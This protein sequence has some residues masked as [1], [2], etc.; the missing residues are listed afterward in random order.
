MNSTP[1]LFTLT[2]HL[3]ID[4]GHSPRK[5]TFMS[6]T[7]ANAL[8]KSDKAQVVLSS[9]SRFPSLLSRRSFPTY[10]F[11]CGPSFVELGNQ[12]VLH[13]NPP[14]S[15]SGFVLTVL[16]VHD[17]EFEDTC[18]HNPLWKTLSN[19]VFEDLRRT[20]A[21][22]IYLSG[23]DYYCLVLCYCSTLINEHD[24]IIYDTLFSPSYL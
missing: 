10:S 2:G 11:G 22:N 5:I 18:S 17:S 19:H 24:V 20:K 12:P 13:F 4:A 3:F 9:L 6:I 21:P 8:W 7:F 14:S 16:H 1:V 15:G 23:L